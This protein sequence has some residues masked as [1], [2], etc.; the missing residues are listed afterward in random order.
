MSAAPK[1]ASGRSEVPWFACCV[2]LG[3]VLGVVGGDVG[4]GL[5][6]GVVLGVAPTVLRAVDVVWS[7]VVALALPAAVVLVLWLVATRGGTR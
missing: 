6:A 1:P 5:G 4:L 3:V 2:V 7:W